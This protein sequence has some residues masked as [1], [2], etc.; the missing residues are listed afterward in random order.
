VAATGAVER[1]A[2]AMDALRSRCGVAQGDSGGV[3]VAVLVG[4]N[5]CGCVGAGFATGRTA[6]D[7]GKALGL[8]SASGK[9]EPFEPFAVWYGPSEPN[10]PAKLGVGGMRGDGAG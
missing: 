6:G 8:R 9:T 7:A 5:G 3:A 2:E 4:T 1:V 10:V